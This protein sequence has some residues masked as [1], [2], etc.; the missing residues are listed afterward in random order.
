[1]EYIIDS[2]PR[3]KRGEIDRRGENQPQEEKVTKTSWE[4]KHPGVVS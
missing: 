1:M 4:M 2:Q 3:K